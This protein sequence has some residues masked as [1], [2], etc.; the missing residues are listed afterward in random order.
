[1]SPP[2]PSNGIQERRRE[3]RLR[4][5]RPTEDRLDQAVNY[6]IAQE[7]TELESAFEL[8]YR[9]YV[10]VGLE[11]NRGEGKLRFTKFHLLPTTKVFTAIYHPDVPTEDWL[12]PS[13]QQ[14]GQV[15]GTLTL[16]IDGPMGLPMEE[17]CGEGVHHLREAG[18]VPA[19]VVGLAVNPEFR[20]LNLMMYIYRLMFEYARWKGVTDL[21]ASVTKR[22]INF[23]RSLLLFEP[24]GSLMPYSGANGLEV[25][26]HRLDM[27]RAERD[28]KRVYGGEPFDCDLFSF[29]FRSSSSRPS[30]EGG[31]WSKQTL[32]RL[33]QRRPQVIQ[34]LSDEERKVLRAEYAR[35][36]GEFPY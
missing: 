2:P 25:Q 35:M 12:R 36:G 18:R 21:C 19:E 8:V 3:V 22:H 27:E 6:R 20:R 34:F 4:R 11:P 31:P 15:V 33:H 30:G 9:S 26:C 14:A 23:Y 32:E 5:S 24:M 28:A 16:I 29:F 17:V 10:E 13:Q 7:V 1:M